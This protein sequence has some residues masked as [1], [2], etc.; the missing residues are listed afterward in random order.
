MNEYSWL[1]RTTDDST[2]SSWSVAKTMA[3]LGVGICQR[4]KSLQSLKGSKTSKRSSVWCAR[5][6]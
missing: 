3:G 5:Q 2:I 4:E 6:G 1:G